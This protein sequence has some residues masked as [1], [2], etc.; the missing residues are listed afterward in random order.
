MKLRWNYPGIRTKIYYVDAQQGSNDNVGYTADAAW[1]TV[2]YASTAAQI[3]RDITNF[4]YDEST[5]IA[6]VTAASHGLFPNSEIKLSGIAFCATAHAGVTT[7]I[8]PDGTQGFF[9]TVGSVTDSDTF[10]TNVGI[11]TIAHD[12]V[13]GGEVTDSS[14]VIL[15]LLVCWCIPRTALLHCLRTSLLL[16]MF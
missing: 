7:T 2:A 10:V 14:P 12:Y 5:G 13:S 16:V 4:V 1:A 11:S 15:K 9:F 3:R 8:F 6:T